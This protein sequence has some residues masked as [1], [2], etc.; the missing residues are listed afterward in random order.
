MAKFS[1]SS[2]SYTFTNIS[3]LISTCLKEKQKGT[4]SP[5]YNKVLLIPVETTYD[6][7]NKLVKLNHDFS[8]CSAKLVKGHT[9]TAGNNSEDDSNNVLLKI[10]Y[11]SFAK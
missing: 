2:N 7:S 9:I 4:A 11:S 6:T 1:S 3:R 5:N 10:V 8:I